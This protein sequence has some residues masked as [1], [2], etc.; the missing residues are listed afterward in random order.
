MSPTIP[1][2]DPPK[3]YT[4]EGAIVLTVSDQDM[5]ESKVVALFSRLYYQP[6]DVLD[7]YLF[8]HFVGH[9]SAARITEKLKSVV[10][11][12]AVERRLAEIDRYQEGYCREFD[13]EID[14]T[15]D[16]EAAQRLKAAG[17]AEMILSQVLPR[18]APS[19]PSRLASPSGQ[20]T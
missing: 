15:V 13:Q 7:I 4:A 10:S 2:A 18:C 3:A 11:P 6:L 8:S 5:V 17:G 1:R 9:D 20:G 14:K 19:S 12:K 16:Q